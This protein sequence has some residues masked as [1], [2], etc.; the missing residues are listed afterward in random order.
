MDAKGHIQNSQI[1]VD[2]ADGEYGNQL[3]VLSGI[4]DALIAIA[5]SLDEMNERGKAEFK[6]KYRREQ[7]LVDEEIRKGFVPPMD[8]MDVVDIG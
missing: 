2:R 6:R 7:R 5:M 8:P 1:L 3:M 4:C